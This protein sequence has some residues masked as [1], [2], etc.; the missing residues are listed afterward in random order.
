M[1]KKVMLIGQVGTANESAGLD[2]TPSCVFNYLERE[3]PADTLSGEARGRPVAFRFSFQ[4]RTMFGCRFP[5][6]LEG[7]YEHLS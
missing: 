6:L 7:Q 2:I 1:E 3:K 5:N 4:K